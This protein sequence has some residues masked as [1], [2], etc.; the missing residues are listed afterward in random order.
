MYFRVNTFIHPAQ[1]GAGPLKRRVIACFRSRKFSSF[2]LLVIYDLSYFLFVAPLLKLLLDGSQASELIFYFMHIFY[3]CFLPSDL[4]V[5]STLQAFYFIFF[6]SHH[7][8]IF[9]EPLLNCSIFIVDY[10]CFINAI[11]FKSW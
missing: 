8:F 2:I 4:E 10:S 3:S 7:C 9:Q 11:P 5:C 1:R 6:L